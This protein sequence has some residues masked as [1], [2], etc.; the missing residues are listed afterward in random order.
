[1]VLLLSFVLGCLACSSVAAHISDEMDHRRWTASDQG[2]SAVGALAQTADGYLWLG[3]HDSLYHFDGFEF[4]KFVPADGEP[5]GVV[6]ALLSTSKGLWVGFRAGG[7]RLI[8]AN[9]VLQPVD[10][11]LPGGVVYDMAED[12]QGHV[13]AATD[14]GLARHDGTGW[15]LVGKEAGFPDRH[16]RAVHVDADGYVWA[17]SEEELYTLPPRASAF[18]RTGIKSQSVSEI[19]SSPAGNIWITDR[20]RDHLLR[21]KKTGYADITF[22]EIPASRT[23]SIVL[24]EQGDAWLGTLGSGK[25]YLAAG[26]RPK[27]GK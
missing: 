8:S 13:W 15:H 26:E 1:M 6:S 19:A 9:G 18:I 12:Q 10:P 23:V 27:S 2:P 25:Q 22:E 17:A 3:T 21:L 11:G 20:S 7:A 16:A 24:D 14:D 5:L 4:E